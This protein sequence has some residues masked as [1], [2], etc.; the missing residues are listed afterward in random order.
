MPDTDY[1]FSEEASEIIGTPP[2]WIIRWGITL[3]FILFAGILAGSYFIKYPRTIK[4]QIVISSFNPPVDLIARR[5]AHI[6]S[7]FV[8][9]DSR[10]QKGDIILMLASTA[11]Y[12]DITCIENHLAHT[13]PPDFLALIRE[14][15]VEQNYVLGEIQSV[16]GAFQT[17]CLDY[18]HYLES[19]VTGG[20][21]RLIEQQLDHNRDY[22]HWLGKQKQIKD[23][24]F[25]FQ[26]RNFQRDSLLY[27]RKMIT[28]VEYENSL[29]ELLEMKSTLIGNETDM[30]T[31]RLSGM[32][33][34]QQAEELSI[35]H[36][37]TIAGFRQNISQSRQDLINSIIS[38]KEQ[39]L[40][41]SPACGRVS[42]VNY[43]HSN[44]WIQVGERLVSIIPEDSEKITGRL[45]IPINGIGSI[46]KGQTVII[47]L[48]SYPYMEYGM[49]NGYINNISAVPDEENQYIAEVIFPEGLTTTRKM[50]LPLIQQMTGEGRIMTKD[51]RLIE[52]FFEKNEK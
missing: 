28:P 45:Y 47:R 8:A 37:N 22:Y 2:R 32:Q 31:A 13:V 23:S 24:V 44:Q 6:D 51:M 50:N 34:Q 35:E 33:T 49:I 16:F 20:K 29:R 10:V 25:L 9:N 43:W 3:V 41:I 21:K 42:F 4:A 5:D 7:F 46:E 12:K 38:W 27:V 48:D 36:A 52:Y 17:Y 26:Y 39:Y 30:A 14:P 11:N 19:D 40:L 18:R 15:W 1:Y